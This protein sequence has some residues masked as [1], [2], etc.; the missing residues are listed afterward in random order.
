M[1]PNP[2]AFPPCIVSSIQDLITGTNSKDRQLL[3]NTTTQFLFSEGIPTAE[4]DRFMEGI[5]AVNP[6]KE[7]PEYHLFTNTKFSCSMLN[8]KGLCRNKDR[9][10]RKVSFPNVY[11]KIRCKKDKKHTLE[12]RK[13]SKYG[14]K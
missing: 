1:Y 13:C 5:G 2:I 3:L 8:Q 11:Y 7:A 9:L 12:E 14:G 4:I 6:G 10:C